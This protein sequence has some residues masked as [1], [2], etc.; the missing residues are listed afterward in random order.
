MSKRSESREAVIWP[1]NSNGTENR[2]KNV[3]ERSKQRL[4]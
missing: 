3:I 4:S 1:S 2:V